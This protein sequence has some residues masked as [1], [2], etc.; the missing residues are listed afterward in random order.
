MV[1]A[2]ALYGLGG[3]GKT[4]V[5]LEYAHR[6]QA[7]YDLIWWVP[8]ERPQEISLALAELAT[9]LGLQTSDNAAEAAGL[10]LERLRRDPPGRW[11]LIFDNAEDPA[12]LEPFLPTGSGHV[13]ITSRNQAWIHH[14]DPVELD[15]FTE[16]ESAEHLQGPERIAA[17]R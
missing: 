17:A 8:A 1:L 6:C 14:A 15:V 10:A 7:D 12:Q 13:I 16:E 3:V 2:R 4:Q 5:A 9:R 11:L